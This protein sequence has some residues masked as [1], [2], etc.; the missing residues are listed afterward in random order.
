MNSSNT[1]EQRSTI[2][3]AFLCAVLLTWSIVS[4]PE[5]LSGTAQLIMFIFLFLGALGS[6][7]GLLTTDDYIKK[8]KSEKEPQKVSIIMTIF[9]V[10][11]QA[12]CIPMLIVDSYVF[13]GYFWLSLV[14]VGAIFSLWVLLL[15]GNWRLTL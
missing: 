7:V 11:V 4:G 10:T 1:R 8:L 5:W 14:I 6:V 15:S 3:G 12:V 13:L 9:R 2:I